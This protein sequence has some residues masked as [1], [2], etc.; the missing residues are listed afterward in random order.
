MGRNILLLNLN[1]API[2]ILPWKKAV[3]LV[4][5]RQK[6]DVVAEYVE[7]KSKIFN[8]AV[9]RLNVKTPDH[10]SLFSKQKFSKKNLFLRD[11]FE[12][13]YCG[14]QCTVR[15]GTIDHI[16]PRSFGGKTDYFNCVIACKRCNWGKDNRTPQ[17]ANMPLR[18]IPK[19]PSLYD[20]FSAMPLPDEWVN[21]V[22]KR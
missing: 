3:G 17:E 1:Y 9:I 12:C 14:I 21:F 5:G 4:L 15:T 6:A 7:P 13:Q 20:L 16:L 2:G 10:F 8:A 22:G 11:R 19:Q 18:S